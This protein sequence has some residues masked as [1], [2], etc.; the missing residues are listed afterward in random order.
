MLASKQYAKAIDTSP[1]KNWLEVL[2]TLTEIYKSDVFKKLLNNPFVSREKIET[3]VFSFFKKLS[4]EQKNVVKLLIKNKRM[5]EL[6]SII[7]HYKQIQLQK[8]KKQE[9]QVTTAQKVT[10][11]QKKMIESFALEFGKKGV[12]PIFEYDIKSDLIGGFTLNIDGYIIDKSI[13]A[14]LHKIGHY[15]EGI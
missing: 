12:I 2:N 13:K 6:S 9:I 11:K 5:G 3:L 7:K 1:G 4:H 14:R 10:P 8:E 15:T